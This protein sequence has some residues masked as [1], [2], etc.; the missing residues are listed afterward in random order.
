MS[1]MMLRQKVKDGSVEEAAAATRDLFA[2]LVR[3]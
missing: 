2:A 1:V 3:K